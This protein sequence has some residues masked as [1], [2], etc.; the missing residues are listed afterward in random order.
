MRVEATLQHLQRVEAIGKIAAGVAHDFN[1][2]L[3]VVLG[4]TVL[5]ERAIGPQAGSKEAGHLAQIRRAVDG[6]TRVTRQLL[7]FSRPHPI[8]PQ[9]LDVNQAVGGI[10]DLLKSSL[11][12]S[13]QFCTQLHEALWSTWADRTQLEMAL[14]NLVIN[15]RDAMPQG[16]VITV[17]TDNARFEPGSVPPGLSPG[18]YVSVSVSDTGTGMSPDV[19]LRA[20]EPFFTTKEPGQGS[21][22]GLGQVADFARLS[23]GGVQLET[24]PGVGTTVHIHLPR[25]S[26]LRHSNASVAQPDAPQHSSLH[27]GSV[28][29]VDDDPAARAV[30][31]SILK[32]GGHAVFEADSGA[33]ALEILTAR[34]IDALVIDYA[35]PIMDGAETARL[36]LDLHPQLP[37]VFLTGYA[38]IAGRRDIGKHRLIEK[39]CRDDDLREAVAAALRG[40]AA[41]S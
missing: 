10:G 32:D 17:R 27:T 38:D 30:T 18:E 29:V 5:I 31:V 37:I 16:G 25:A 41:R 36:A 39:P 4:S 9:L 20:F 14:L 28:L 23:G 24:M 3:A 40:A 12:G 11:A 13:I 15:A 1:N 33:L 22:V 19:I 2:L 34:Q 8:E 35:M 21:G 26:A 7:A 6:G